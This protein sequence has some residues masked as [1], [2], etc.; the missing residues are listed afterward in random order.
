MSDFQISP[1]LLTIYLEDARGHL[2]ALDHAL[3]ALERDGL[4][5]EVIAAV[6]GPL[7]TLKGNSGMMGFTGIKDYVHRL[8]DVLAQVREGNVRLTPAAFDVLFG[9]ASGLRDAVERACTEAQEA[10]DLVPERAAL[11]VLLTQE[12]GRAPE[13][14]RAAAPQPAASEP[15]PT[16]AD[17]EAPAD[18]GRRAVDTRHV[19]VRSNMVRVDFGQLDNLLNLVGELIIYRT[20]LHQVG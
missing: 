13:A 10:R 12:A 9:G 4:D 7:H 19:A 11:D 14:G 18:W 1:E 20:K 3:L 2:E 17:P 15:P 16:E 6:L 8:E 5:A